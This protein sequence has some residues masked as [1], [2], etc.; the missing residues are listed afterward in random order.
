VEPNDVITVLM[1]IIAVLTGIISGFSTSWISRCL[2]ASK[3]SAL[4]TG[5]GSF[6]A[7]TGLMIAIMSLA[8][9]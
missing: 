4:S 6:A 7:S 5:F 8:R 1:V 2:G 3:V 9:T